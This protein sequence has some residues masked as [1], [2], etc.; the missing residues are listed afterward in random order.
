MC[1]DTPDDGQFEERECELESCPESCLIELGGD[2]TP[3]FNV[4]LDAEDGLRSPRDIAFSPHPGRHLGSY[5]EGR[6]FS[7]VGDEL[8]VANGHAHNIVIVPDILSNDQAAL[9]RGD[10]GYYHYMANITSLAFNNVGNADRASRDTFGYFATCQDSANTY[11]GLKEPNFFMGPSLYDSSPEHKNVVS[12]SGE[13]CSEADECYLLHADMLH[14][15]PQCRGILHDPEVE[16]AYGTVYWA[17]DGHNSQLVRY[18]FSQPHGPGFMDH[19]VAQ[20]RRYPEVTFTEGEEI[21]TRG[22]LL[23]MAVDAQKRVLYVSDTAGGRVLFVHADSG[24]FARTARGEYPIYSSRLPSFEYSIYECVTW[25]V[26][27][28]GVG[29]PSGLA[30]NQGTLYVGDHASGVIHAFDVATGEATTRLLTPEGEGLA[31]LAVAPLS[32]RMFY[33]NMLSNTVAAVV[34]GTCEDALV[35]KMVNDRF[36]VA[37]HKM[38]REIHQ[39]PCFPAMTIPDIVYFDQ[40]HVDTGY[41]S[42]N[43]AVQNDSMVDADAILLQNRTDCG[44]NSSLNFDALLLGGYFC[45]TCLPEGCFD[46]G[47]CSNVQWAGFTCSNEFYVTIDSDNESVLVNGKV[48]PTLDVEVGKTYRFII[49]NRGHL[50]HLHDKNGMSIDGSEGVEAGILRVSFRSDYPSEIVYSMPSLGSGSQTTGTIRVIGG[51]IG[52]TFPPAPSPFSAGSALR[53]TAFVTCCI[54]LICGWL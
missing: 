40:V 15:S 33:S 32:G 28:T 41:A 53:S 29:R 35:A 48:G 21:S 31:G 14:E 2:A 6:S 42:S 9:Q 47:V 18:D 5:A 45:H 36:D 30:L 3:V 1:N 49:E 27:A 24:T 52:G 10:R 8:W 26:F 38:L 50:F 13:R 43:A 4:A 20:V 25:G 11:L 34:R 54:A 39:A 37:Q 12:R 17:F 22:V 19:S 51:T 44:F 16:T 23:G 7:T 46:G